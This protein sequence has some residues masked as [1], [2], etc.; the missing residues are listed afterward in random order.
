MNAARVL[1]LFASLPEEARAPAA[2][3]LCQIAHDL[4]S[5]LSTL[6]M[7]VFSVRLVLGNLGSSNAAAAL[8]NLDE[9]SVNMERASAQL[10]EYLASLASLGADSSRAV[11]PGESVLPRE[12]T[13]FG[14]P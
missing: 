2:R 12:A 1:D 8:T 4:Q 13:P 7:E 14:K 9:I 3:L 11:V 10:A 5:P 6:A